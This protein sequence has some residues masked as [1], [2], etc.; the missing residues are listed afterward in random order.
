[1]SK[2]ENKPLDQ[3]YAYQWNYESQSAHDRK[4]RKRKER[5]GGAVYALVMVSAFVLCLALLVGTILINGRETPSDALTVAEVAEQVNPGTV[6][7]YAADDVSSGYGTGFFVRTDGCIVTNYHIVEGAKKITVTLYSGE[8][9]EAETLWYSSVDD[10]AVIKVDGTGYPTLKIGNSDEVSVGDTAIAIGNP[11]G[12]LCPW[13]TTQ[14][15]ISA[16]ERE[17]TVEGLR[18]IADLT[19]LQ[20]DAQVNPGNSGGPLCN[21]RG[22][23]IGIVARKMTDYEGLGLAIPINGAMELVNAYLNTGTSSGVVSSISKV[24]P[25]IGIQAAAVKAGDPITD[26]FS[27][28]KDCVLVVSVTEGG[29]ADGVLQ[30]GDL[31]LSANGRA[32]TDMN[33]LKEILYACGMGDSLQLRVNRFGTVMDLT[34][35]FGTAGG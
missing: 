8:E 34:V 32:V 12:N 25:T 13:T 6:L 21:D 27:A 10:L 11:A 3:P 1:M 33:V 15:I 18:S 35:T 4:D 9:L 16:V 5:R 14:G 20:T 19:M 29:S 31:I 24:R 30:A 2:Q 26:D 23:V 22:E 28:P 7:I 17:V